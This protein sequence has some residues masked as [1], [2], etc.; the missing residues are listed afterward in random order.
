MTIPNR[1]LLS[2]D[3]LL[4]T[5]ARWVAEVRAQRPPWWRPLA[6]ALWRV[7]LEMLERMDVS[8]VA[9]RLRGA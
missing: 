6:R 1:A 9:A 3:T 8:E 7:E 4:E 2:L 5:R